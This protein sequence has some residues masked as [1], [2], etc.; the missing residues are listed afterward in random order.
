M[1]YKKYSF[2]SE[3]EALDLIHDLGHYVEN[4]EVFASYKH[5]VVKLGFLQVGDADEETPPTFSDKYSVDVLWKDLE[6]DKN[7]NPIFPEGWVENEL[8]GLSKYKHNFNG[9]TF[10]E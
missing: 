4:G 6:L 3:S 9:L 10:E 7:E 8:N 5:T 1:I 2:Q